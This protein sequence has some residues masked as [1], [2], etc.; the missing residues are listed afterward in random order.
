MS[1]DLE[2]NHLNL[3]RRHLLALGGASLAACALPVRASDAWPAKP[4]RIIAGQAPGSSNDSTARALADYLAQKLGVPVVVENK[5]GGSGMIA[6]DAVAR[7]SPDGYTLLLS[8]HSQLAQAPV[9]L[10]KPPV[11][12]DKDLVPIAAMGVG[13]VIGVV[14][15]D[16]PAQ[17]LEQVIAY[18]KKKPVNV[19]NYSVGSGW[20]LMLA[21]LAKDTGGQ[22]NVVNYKGTGA[23][24]MDLYA[25]T[26]DMGAGSLAGMGAGLDKGATKPVVITVGEKSRRLPGI[27]RWVDA[28][29]KGPAYEDLAECNMLFAPAGTSPDVVRRLADLAA[30]S[31]NDSPRIKAVRETL[32][33]EGPVLTGEE[34]KKFIERTWPSYRRLTRELNL[35]VD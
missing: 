16:F 33:E 35:V 2:K 29:F 21:Q 27:P 22:F 9:L 23:M 26:I 5:P 3:G 32:H 24:L 13:P 10:K 7:S 4:I 14:N 1:L 15:K 11:N 28:G 30:L 31:A 8:L 17:T 6:A 19:G 20:Q 18:S 12:T 25:G 34:L